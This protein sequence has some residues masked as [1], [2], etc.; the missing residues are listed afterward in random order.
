M[1]RP[2]TLQFRQVKVPP[3]VID[4]GIGQP[5]DSVLPVELMGRAAAA[6]FATGDPDLLQYGADYGNGAHR[7]ALAEFL[8]DGYGFPVDPEWLLTSNGNSQALN[9]VCT[10][11][12]HPGDVVIVEEPT[13]FLAWGIFL[14]HGLEAVGV[15]MDGDGL[16]VD[17]LEATIVKMKERGRAPRLIYTIP[18][19]HNPTG[20]TLAAERRRRLVEIARRHEVLVVADE[21]YHFLDYDAGAVPALSHWADSGWVISLGSFSKILAPALRLGWIHATPDHLDRLAHSGLIVSGGGLNPITSS[22]VTEVIKA[23]GLTEH[24]RFLCETFARRVATMHE[25]LG[26]EMADGVSWARPAGGYFFWLRLPDGH[27]AQELRDR[28]RDFQV[29]FRP[30]RLFS[31]QGGLHEHLRLSHAYYREPELVAGVERVGRALSSFL[32]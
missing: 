19:F 21:V 3:G 24:I 31:S 18:S 13:Y 10:V 28:A 20:V 1:T 32:R 17:E 27:D 9:L 4:L 15:P 2:S 14:D 30:G 11:F 25:V 29:D 12:T 22:L 5:D 8:T 6:A 26:S 23:G 7:L 16:D